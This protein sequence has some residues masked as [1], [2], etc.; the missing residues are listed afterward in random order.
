MSITSGDE[1]FG[2]TISSLL[3]AK[4]ERAETNED[5]LSSGRREARKILAVMNINRANDRI[6]S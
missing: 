2:F 5:S 6:I 4:S 3:S 1:I